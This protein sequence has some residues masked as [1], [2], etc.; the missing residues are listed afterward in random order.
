MSKDKRQI[1]VICFVW[2][3]TWCEMVLYEAERFVFKSWYWLLRH[4]F[5]G[6]NYNLCSFPTFLSVKWRKDMHDWIVIVVNIICERQLGLNSNLIIW[7]LYQAACVSLG[8]VFDFLFYPPHSDANEYPALVLGGWRSC[9]IVCVAHI[10]GCS[11][12]GLEKVS[13]GMVFWKR[14]LHSQWA[15]TSTGSKLYFLASSPSLSLL[16]DFYT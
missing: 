4:W 7:G 14:T 1:N 12:Q 8:N 10:T 13:N 3:C 2:I 6:K 9:H 5:L 11:S 15:C 16:C